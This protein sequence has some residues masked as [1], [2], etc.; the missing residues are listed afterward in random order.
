MDRAMSRHCSEKLCMLYC[1]REEG[2]EGLQC[3][4]GQDSGKC[5]LFPGLPGYEFQELVV[6][7]CLGKAGDHGLRRLLDL[8]GDERPAEE[9]D[10][11]ELL[12]VDQELLLAGAGGRD[13]DRGP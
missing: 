4:L 3:G 5:E 7:L 9:V 10:V 8:L 1:R 11:L 6:R 2:A 12:R 13:V